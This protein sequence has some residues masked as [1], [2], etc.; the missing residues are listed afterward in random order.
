[1]KPSDY[2]LLASISAFAVNAE[3]N[4]EQ[5]TTSEITEK[6][7]SQGVDLMRLDALTLRK[8][9]KFRP[10]MD[11]A[12]RARGWS[13][14]ARLDHGLL[15]AGKSDAHID[16]EEPNETDADSPEPGS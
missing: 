8:L 16:N 15:I 7:E 4:S 5:L 2:K 11:S 12:S 3:E 13:T 9:K 14:S 6:L 10:Q 1:M